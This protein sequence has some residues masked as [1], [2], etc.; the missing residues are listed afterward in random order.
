LQLTRRRAPKELGVPTRQVLVG[1]SI[2]SHVHSTRRQAGI[3]P[4]VEPGGYMCLMSLSEL[5]DGALVARCR[6]G[7]EAAWRELVERFS[8]Y[9]YAITTQAFRLGHDDAE[10]VFQEVFAR[11]YE[12]LHR[13]RDDEAIRPWLAQMTR[14]LA[15]D[16]I[17]SRSREE[18]RDEDAEPADF[19]QALVR[20]DEALELREGLA[21]LPEHCR[22]VLDRFF[23]RDESYETIGAALDIAPGTI[24]SRISRCLGKLRLWFEGR[25]EAAV[26]SGER[27]TT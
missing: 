9:V 12:N 23:A 2:S 24:A 4:L 15:I 6:T 19:D 16:R 8:R 21:T 13:L 3:F 11:T 27:V 17:R 7:D 25:S 18:L 10:E 26:T 20:L 22:E 1:S 14:R 5:G